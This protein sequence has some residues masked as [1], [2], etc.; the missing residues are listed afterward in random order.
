MRGTVKL[1]PLLV[2]A[3]FLIVPLLVSAVVPTAPLIEMLPSPCRSI[4]PLLVKAA[5]PPMNIEPPVRLMTPAV[6]I[7]VPVM[8]RLGL[9]LMV[10]PMGTETW[11]LPLNV[12]LFQVIDAAVTLI[13]AVPWSVAP[14]IV[15]VGMVSGE[16][17]LRVSV[18]PLAVRLPTEVMLLSVVV[19]KEW[20]VAATL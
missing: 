6:L 11:P 18:P 16:A 8:V 20:I 13:G 12:P 10:V 19:P 7:G 4:V 9:M 14:D 5:F 15:S 3:L 17:L 1:E 2:P